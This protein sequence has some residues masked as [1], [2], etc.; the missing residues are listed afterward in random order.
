LSVS[1]DYAVMSAFLRRPRSGVMPMLVRDKRSREGGRTRQGEVGVEDDDG[2][3]GGGE[4]SERTERD[5]DGTSEICDGVHRVHISDQMGRRL[6]RAGKRTGQPARA[7]TAG[8]QTERPSQGTRDL[9][10]SHRAGSP[11][12]GFHGTSLSPNWQGMH[13][14]RAKF[15]RQGMQRT[16]ANFSA[17]PVDGQTVIAS[18]PELRV[19]RS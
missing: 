7:R 10:A 12:S 16:Q 9:F 6:D 18:R 14:D 11:P 13:L 5:Q 15:S 3:E 19:H 1:E 8:G 4:Q 17:E 2:T